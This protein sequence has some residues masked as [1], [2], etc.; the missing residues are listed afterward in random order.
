MV[1]LTTGT[2]VHENHAVVNLV[3]AHLV[4]GEKI[5]V[6]VAV[7]K[8]VVAEKDDCEVVDVDD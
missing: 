4:A 7:V 6:V 1:V 2:G 8:V 3:A 5:F